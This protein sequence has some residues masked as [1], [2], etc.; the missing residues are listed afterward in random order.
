MR[1]L[2]TGAS[3]FVGGA[4]LEVLVGKGN[5]DAIAAVHRKPINCPES[6]RVIDGCELSASMDWSPFLSE[7]DVVVHSAARVH[8]MNDQSS[9]PL[10]AFR[11][12]N[13][14]GTMRLAQQ[15]ALAGVRRFVFLSSIKV[16]GEE[17]ANHVSYSPDTT[18][19][20][21]DPYGIS[22]L[23]AEIQLKALAEKSGM[24]IVIIRPVLVYGPGVKAN[25]RK[26][27]QLLDKGWPL[28]FGTIRNQRSFVAL[29]NLIDLI[30]LCM[31][32]PNAANQTFMVSDG[33]DLSTT[34][35]LNKMAVALGKPA[36][37]FPFPVSV[38]KVG[39]A[40]FGKTDIWRRLCGSLRVDISK[41]RDVLGWEPKISVDSAL[42]MS[43]LEYQ[44]SLK[45]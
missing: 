34:E 30:I 42:K 33:E 31:D 4:L 12:V 2:I 37:L 26:M 8:I 45:R 28:P 25:F 1:V 43:A 3:G 11:A 39:A 18:P 40:L 19:A 5:I 36:R 21:S 41:T 44:E 38:L 17:T 13:V 22:K 20:P 27:M 15:A 10:E 23:E 6:V 29:D 7:V 9:N 32:H 16:N 35:L 24:E 14:H